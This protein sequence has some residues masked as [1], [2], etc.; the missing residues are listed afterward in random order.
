MP[1]LH[2]TT[3]GNAPNRPSL[4]LR[5]AAATVAAALRQCGMPHGGDRDVT[6]T[7]VSIELFDIGE[8]DA[9]R[10][11]VPRAERGR[12]MGFTAGEPG[13]VYGGPIGALPLSTGVPE[14][15][16]NQAPWFL[17]LPVEAFELAKSLREELLSI[18]RKLYREEEPPL[19][20]AIAANGD[21]L[22]IRLEFQTRENRKI[23][24]AGKEDQLIDKLRRAIF[25]EFGIG[26]KL[27]VGRLAR[28][29]SPA[30][31]PLNFVGSGVSL[32]VGPGSHFTA[33]YACLDQ[34][35]RRI[36]VTSG[37]GV[38]RSPHR[39]VFQPRF[40]DLQDR[41]VGNIIEI[42]FDAEFGRTVN[43]MDAAVIDVGQEFGL[44]NPNSYRIIGHQDLDFSLPG[45]NV[46]IL[47][48]DAVKSARIVEPRI[49]AGS[50]YDRTGT[51]FLYGNMFSLESL[52][53]PHTRPWPVTVDGDSGAPVIKQLPSGD[54]ALIG[55]IVGGAQ[56]GGNLRRPLSYALPIGPIVKR[57]GLP[58][59]DL[60]GGP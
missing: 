11:L 55:M 27:T 10:A 3:L 60:G 32:G 56:R 33:T 38:S 23:P 14:S 49:F 51:L 54:Y 57:L 41:R 16:P 20:V 12:M 13:R 29:Q 2:P 5:V 53:P 50:L 6:R 4:N 47:G 1:A 43:Y 21:I 15:L 39:A 59:V 22:N 28:L 48:S 35:Q 19:G 9:A 34:N 37:H 40:T 18:R 8:L 44:R 17:A 25:G 52:S 42:L 46:L 26:L 30:D 45:T 58:L 7:D 31:D 36:V 24:P